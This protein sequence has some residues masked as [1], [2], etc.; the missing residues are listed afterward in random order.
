MARSFLHRA[1]L[2]WISIV[3]IIFFDGHRPTGNL[4]VA[5]QPSPSLHG[6]TETSNISGDRCR[7]IGRSCLSEANVRNS[8]LLE[9][10]AGRVPCSCLTE[11]RLSI[12]CIKWILALHLGWYMKHS[13]LSHSRPHWSVPVLSETKQEL[14]YY[15]NLWYKY[16]GYSND[17]V[18]YR[19]ARSQGR[20]L[21]GR[22]PAEGGVP[23]FA[24]DKEKEK[25]KEGKRKRKGRKKEKQ[26]KKEKEKKEKRKKEEKKIVIKESG[27]F[28]AKPKI[29][30]IG[31]CNQ[32][33]SIESSKLND[34]E[35]ESKYQV[36]DKRVKINVSSWNTKTQWILLSFFHLFK[37]DP[38]QKPMII[39]DQ[40]M[41]NSRLRTA[42]SV[43]SRHPG[44]IEH[45]Y[46][47]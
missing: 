42:L 29:I 43:N 6:V 19:Q 1:T 4:P 17:Q 40:P 21:G 33:E 8:H 41:W 34:L 39:V 22:P 24:E 32:I 2:D 45:S 23:P 36:V 11:A 20:A 16:L 7:Y 14:L 26:K 30:W 28:A 27:F 44:W 46:G 15:S 37:F 10:N 38:L 12:N 25:E 18:W 9:T 3:D 13:L 31:W 35:L 5:R 47:E